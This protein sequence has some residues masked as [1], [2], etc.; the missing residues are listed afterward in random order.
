VR[1]VRAAAEQ[2]DAGRDGG[3][4]LGQ[5]AKVGGGPAVVGRDH[6][7]GPRGL[8]GEQAMGL[9]FERALESWCRCFS[10]STSAS[11]ARR[12][13]AGRSSIDEEKT[14]AE[15]AQ[16]AGAQVEGLEGTVSAHEAHAAAALVP[17]VAQDH[18]HADLEVERGW[19]PPQACRSKPSASTEAHASPA[20]RAR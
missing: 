19:V 5:E 8:A 9:A 16:E 13:A 6:D 17:L 12:P 15:V 3:Q 18:D 11:A 7:R 4:L 1:L 10:P 2:R 20:R 14:A